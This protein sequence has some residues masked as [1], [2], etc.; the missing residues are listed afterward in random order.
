MLSPAHNVFGVEQVPF[1]LQAAVASELRLSSGKDCRSLQPCLLIDGCCASAQL[2]DHIVGLIKLDPLQPVLA[3]EAEPVE[4]RL[5]LLV[6]HGQ[7]ELSS[8]SLWRG[9]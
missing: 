2:T 9:D 6:P 4:Y 8:W 7:A 3:L 5:A 1:A